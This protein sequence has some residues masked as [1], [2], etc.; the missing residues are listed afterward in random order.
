MLSKNVKWLLIG[1]V[2]VS[3]VLAACGATSEPEATSAPTEAAQPTSPPKETLR[4]AFVYVAPIGDLGWTYAHDEGRLAL[5][6][7]FGDKVETAYIEN[8]PEGPDAERVIR[9]F[10][11]KGYDLILTTSFGFM[12][13]T[14]TVA[15]EYPD[16]WFVHISGYKTAENLSTL[17]GRIY[18]PRFL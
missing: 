15:E 4:V 10:A 14:A 3:M 5:E 16:T 8:V 18:Q 1:L 2:I 17:F 7:H 6:E 11:E 12:D 9:D 13:P